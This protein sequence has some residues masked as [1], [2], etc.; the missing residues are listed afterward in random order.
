[1]AAAGDNSHRPLLLF[2]LP[3]HFFLLT[4]NPSFSL[5][6]FVPNTSSAD[7]DRPRSSPNLSS[8]KPATTTT[9]VDTT[10]SPARESS[11]VS[12][13]VDAEVDVC[14]VGAGIT[15]LST[16]F[17]LKEKGITNI[18]LLESSSRP[19]GC[20]HT[21][22]APSSS[23]SSPPYICELGANSFQCPPAGNSAVAELVERLGLHESLLVADSRLP[24]YV[25]NGGELFKVPLSLREWWQTKLISRKGKWRMLKGLFGLGTGR[26]TGRRFGESRDESDDESVGDLVGRHLGEEVVEKLV[27]PFVAG[28]YAGD[29]YNI[30]CKAAFPKIYELLHGQRSLLWSFVCA[31]A[32]R[33]C[34]GGSWRGS[35]TVCSFRGGMR[36][37]V[38]ALIQQ[39]EGSGEGGEEKKKKIW[40]GSKVRRIWAE[41]KTKREKRWFCEIMRPDKSVHIIRSKQLVLTGSAHDCASLLSTIPVASSQTS[42]HHHQHLCSV[43]KSI[44]HVDVAVVC[45]AYPLAALKTPNSTSG[46]GHLIPPSEGLASLGAIWASSLFPSDNRCPQG[47]VMFTAFLGGG[48]G[49]RMSVDVCGTAPSRLVDIAHKELAQ[50]MLKKDSALAPLPR[51]LPFRPH[52]TNL[53][54]ISSTTKP[55]TTTTAGVVVCAKQ[56]RNCIPQLVKGHAQ[57]MRRVER[58]LKQVGGLSLE[59]GWRTGVAVHARLQAARRLAEEL[60]LLV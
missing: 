45:L 57:K 19:G 27:S 56:W 48:G 3:I 11:A 58:L 36:Q 35:S 5:A 1:M 31:K 4:F 29:A 42:T 9:T 22:C 8:T 51:N 10:S 28:V 7:H 53:Y 40:L 52:Q 39:I 26:R 46:F 47:Q 16:A 2:L 14:I 50:I 24:R 12:G 43:L 32:R 60:A 21:V 13:G 17:Y 38:E 30:S 15:G 54:I 6:S 49:E 59:G 41:Q 44:P 18:A 23:S 55:P 33:L 20:L 37:L 34:R 25:V